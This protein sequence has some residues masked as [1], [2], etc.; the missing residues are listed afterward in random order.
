MLYTY[1]LTDKVDPGK[2]RSLLTIAATA[3]EGLHGRA[4]MILDIHFSY[5][6]EESS[7]VIDGHSTAGKDM[8]KIFTCLLSKQCGESSFTVSTERPVT[9]A[10]LEE[11]DKLYTGYEEDDSDLLN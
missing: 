6:P 2:L 11:L 3:V 10:E 7:V 9:K 4:V 5:D 1:R 8:A